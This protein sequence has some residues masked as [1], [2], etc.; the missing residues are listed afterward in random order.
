MRP[1]AAPLRQAVRSLARTPAFTAAVVAVLA[2]G[3]GATTSMFSVVYGVLLRP[4][5]F[6]EPERLVRVWTQFLPGLGRGAVS[7]ANGRDWRAQNHVFEDLALVSTS[8]QFNYS[9]RGEPER[10]RGARVSAGF[11]SI[12][13]ATPLLG[14]T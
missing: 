13:R 8:R 6:A 9:G 10:L 4:L 2:L 14:R 3:I 7:A 1:F 12:L 5:P 11:F